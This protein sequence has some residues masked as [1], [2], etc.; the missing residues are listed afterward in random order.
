M[1]RHI[2]NGFGSG[3]AESANERF[4]NDLRRFQMSSADEVEAIWAPITERDDWSAFHAKLA[5]IEAARVAY[6]LS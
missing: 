1:W 4:S 6:A 5:A 2:V 3:L